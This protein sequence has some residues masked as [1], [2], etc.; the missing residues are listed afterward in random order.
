MASFQHPELSREFDDLIW[1]HSE[2]GSEALHGRAV[3]PLGQPT[4]DA[5]DRP[6]RHSRL[7]GELAVTQATFSAPISKRPHSSPSR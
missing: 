3:D 7:F 6:S 4:F 2:R 5:G 1:C